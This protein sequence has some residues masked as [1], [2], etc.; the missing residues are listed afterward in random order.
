MPINYCPSHVRAAMI[1]SLRRAYERYSIELTEFDIF[2]MSDLIL[3]GHAKFKKRYATR[4]M[5]KLQYLGKNF[6][7]IFDSVLMVIVTFLP[8]KALRQV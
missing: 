8:R 4:T 7:L 1:H 6:V 3:Q 5:Y 2:R